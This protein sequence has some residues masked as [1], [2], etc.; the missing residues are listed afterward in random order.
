MDLV[1]SIDA[2]DGLIMHHR[3]LQ[4]WVGMQTLLAATSKEGS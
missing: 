4:G 3:V 1:E 2:E